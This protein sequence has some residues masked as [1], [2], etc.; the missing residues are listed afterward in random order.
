MAL[1]YRQAWQ[2][3]IDKEK[4]AFQMYHELARL[5]TRFSEI[6]I[7]VTGCGRNQA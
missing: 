1:E 2:L 6:P 7:Y 4:A 3:A 5:L